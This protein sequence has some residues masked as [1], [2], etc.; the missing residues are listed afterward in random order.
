MLKDA[1]K[2]S[3]GNTLAWRRKRRLRD[4]RWSAYGT[5]VVIP[6]PLLFLH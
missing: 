3:E 2:S 6:A 1:F 4:T 5:T